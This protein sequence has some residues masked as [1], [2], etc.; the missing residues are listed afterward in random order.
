MDTFTKIKTLID[1]FKIEETERINEIIKGLEEFKNFS[2]IMSPDDTNIS[3]FINNEIESKKVNLI[4]L[5]S[6][7]KELIQFLYNFDLKNYNTVEMLEQITNFIQNTFYKTRHS[8][9]IKTLKNEIYKEFNIKTQ[10][11]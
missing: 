8:N 5:D 1:A 7:W 9:T 3:N 11:N 4:F 2:M 10:N 6:F